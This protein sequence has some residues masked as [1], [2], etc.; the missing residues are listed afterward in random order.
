MELNHSKGMLRI[1]NRAPSNAPTNM[2]RCAV[3]PPSRIAVRI[4]DVKLR[5]TCAMDKLYRSTFTSHM[6][7]RRGKK[8]Y[9][10]AH[11]WLVSCVHT[12]RALLRDICCLSAIYP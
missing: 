5:A 8:D 10:M 1:P 4:P 7:G 6:T 2:A 3:L 12:A 9:G 11:R